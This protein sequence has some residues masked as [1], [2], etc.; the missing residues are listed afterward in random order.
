MWGSFLESTRRCRCP[1]LDGRG[2][3]AAT[4]GERGAKPTSIKSR[5]R[6]D[7]LEP[8]SFFWGAA[9]P[10]WREAERMRSLVNACHRVNHAAHN[11]SNR[12]KVSALGR[13]HAPTFTGPQRHGQALLRSVPVEVASRPAS[14]RARG[15]K[16]S[17]RA[18]WCRRRESVPEQNTARL[19]VGPKPARPRSACPGVAGGR[20]DD[21]H[22]LG[23]D[24]SRDDFSCRAGSQ[25]LLAAGD[26]RLGQGNAL[27]A[28]LRAFA[29][30]SPGPSPPPG[31]RPRGCPGRPPT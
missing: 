6:V 25:D 4:A 15:A 23:T 7:R 14:A 13:P 12:Y 26:G 28:R 3:A 21:E 5:K 17:S 29:P 11:Y 22:I 9:T 8:Y 10:Q 24:R 20:A 2:H 16:S 18:R 19:L 27:A 31:R 1:W 30:T